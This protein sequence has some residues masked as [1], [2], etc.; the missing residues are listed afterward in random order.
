MS[1]QTTDTIL[2]IRPVR[3]EFNI[4]TAVNNY[5]QQNTAS[6]DNR[7]TQQKALLEFDRFVLKLQKEGVHVI[8]VDDT[9]NPHTPDSIFPNNWVSFHYDGSVLFYPMFAK[10]RR[11]ERQEDL[12]TLLQKEHKLYV[13][14]KID[15]SDWE[16][17]NLFLEGTGSLVLDRVNKIAYG[18]LSERTNEE[19]VEQFVDNLEYSS[20]LFTA[21]QTVD[22]LRLPI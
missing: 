18:A 2:M 1:T 15:L 6:E 12:I 10:N 21:K 14:Q 11:Q 16:D 7:K 3:F 4:Q 17:Q 20:V 9:L 19:V 22:K 5:Y 13:S 8:V